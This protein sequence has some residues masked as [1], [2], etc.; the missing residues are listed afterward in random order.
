[1]QMSGVDAKSHFLMPT[2]AKDVTKAATTIAGGG[3]SSI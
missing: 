2:C 1:V 3:S